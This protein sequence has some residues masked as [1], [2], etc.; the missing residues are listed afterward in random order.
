MGSLA[1]AAILF[2]VGW[3]VGSANERAHLRRLAFSEKNLAHIRVCNIKTVPDDLYPGGM[4]VTGNCVVAIDYFK[5]VLSVIRMF[6]GGRLNSYETLLTR[7]RREALVRLMQKADDL[8]ATAVYNVRY[9][10]SAIGAQPHAIG[11]VEMLA[12]GTAVKH[13]TGPAA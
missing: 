5:K 12:Y 6:F 1:F 7:A 10:F 9:E 11:G 3:I 2:L 4:L 13:T 8:G